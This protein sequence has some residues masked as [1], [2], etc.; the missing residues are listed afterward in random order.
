MAWLLVGRDFRFGAGR[1]GDYAALE[2]AALRYG[3]ELEAMPEVKLEGER[4][5]S[6]AVRAALAAGD[7]A[8]AARLLGHGYAISGRV[9]RGARLGRNLG[10]PT[11]NIALRHRPPLAGIFVV[12]AGKDHHRRLALGRQHLYFPLHQSGHLGVRRAQ[13]NSYDDVSHDSVLLCKRSAL[14]MKGNFVLILFW[15]TADC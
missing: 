14:S 6:S 12:E 13:I 10:F 1:A 7:F 9:V 15:L 8:R 11:A 2:A 3:F 5:S 4:V